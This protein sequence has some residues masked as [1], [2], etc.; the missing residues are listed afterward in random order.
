M[1]DAI[2]FYFYL[3]ILSGLISLNLSVYIWLKYW[4]TKKIQPART[5]SLLLLGVCIWALGSALAMIG[6]NHSLIYFWEQFKYI[7]ILIIPP[8]WAIVSLIWTGRSSWMTPLKIGS[9]YIA[10]VIFMAL[11]FTDSY[12]H[13]IWERIEYLG[14]GPYT[15][16][17]T[18]HGI[19]WWA[20]WVYSYALI[21]IGVMYLLNGLL[22]TRYI[23]QKQAL[24]LL[25]G[26]LIPWVTNALYA[27]NIGP[28]AIVDFTPAAFI[29]TGITYAWGFSHLQLIDTPPFAKHA[30]FEHLDDPVFVFDSNY[31]L[32]EINPC[33]E[34]LFQLKGKELIGADT[35]VV[36][37]NQPTLIT[38][39]KC[40]ENSIS[41]FSFEHDNKK[42]VFDVHV[43]SLSDKKDQCIGYLLSLRDIS[44][45]KKTEDALLDSE[46]KFRT[47]T[48][49]ASVAIMIHQY[50]KWIYANPAAE[51]ITG[52]S[53]SELLSM[54]F[55]EFVHPDY[56]DTIIRQGR[57]RQLGENPKNHYE[58]KI[59]SKKGTVKWVDFRAKSIQYQGKTAA[60]I[61]AI[62]ITD[63]KHAEETMDKQLAAIT[64]SIDGIAILNP[65]QIYEYVND[66]HAT[67]YGYG[68]TDE[69]IGKSWTMLYED[70]E[71]HRF[72]E[73]IIPQLKKEGRWRGEA[74]GRKKNGTAFDQEVTLTTLSDGGLICVVRDITKQKM[75]INELQDAHV[76]LYTVN[77]DL[78]RKVKE[79]TAQIEKLIKQK[80]DFINQLGHDL[81]TPLTPMMVL[82][83][84]LKEKVQSEKDNELFEVVIRNV[85]FMKDLVNKTIDLAKLNSD[86]IEFSMES[87]DIADTTSL[88]IKN[89]QVL[90]E[91]NHINIIN[92]I[93]EPSFV[94]ADS[95][96]LSEVFNNLITNAIKY[97]PKE[98]GTI[99]IDASEDRNM[100][101]ISVKDTGIG[102]T[103]EQL[104]Q[105][106]DEFYKADESR[107]DLDSSG[108]GL[109][110]TKKII[111]KHGGSVWAESEGKGKGSTFYFTLQKAKEEDQK[112]SPAEQIE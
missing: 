102:M 66:A 77:K 59:I 74:V 81:K 35:G 38:L 68:S 107:H 6:Q 5:F 85:Y 97:M 17:A 112:V 54:Y 41:E 62:D 80:D 53:N 110:I 61:I 26:S 10:P 51:R 13:L 56:T 57:A 36:F 108:L 95:L 94:I 65:Q 27:F 8:S 3:L 18:V 104:N 71:L 9:L 19:A 33:A 79:R 14:F 20:M 96:R 4:A 75:V 73:D 72:Q 87:I 11:I 55:W 42:Q 76:L 103:E 31:R 1:I 48:E 50:D 52:Y 22:N 43:T 93:I 105:I 98:G 29:V 78:E 64:S 63:R 39:F 24:L 12:H 99:T 92:H 30:V 106:F 44:E 82:L 45:R 100:I 40:S 49:S 37:A 67:I 89:N 84:L 21:L 2:E 34:A 60:L 83:P 16:T 86:R 32:L 23:Y 70:D 25:I 47:F 69:L 90:F 111:E 91:K 109:T 58:F 88:V 15:M 7:G 101:I 28:Y 46:K